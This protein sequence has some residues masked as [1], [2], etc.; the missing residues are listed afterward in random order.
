MLKLRRSRTQT[1]LLLILVLVASQGFVFY[2][3]FH[4]A[5]LPG[6]QQFNRILAYEVDLMLDQA[7]V[8]EQA[9]ALS[10]SLQRHLLKQLGLTLHHSDEPLAAEFEHATQ[11][12]FLSDDMSRDL[13]TPAEVRL[14]LGHESYVL[15]IRIEAFPH[16]L[17]RIPLSELQE[18]DFA[19]LFYNSILMALLIIGCSWVYIRLRNRPLIALEQAALKV[20]RGET[21]SPL[22]VSG[23]TEIRA[24]TKAFNQ[25]SKGIQALEDDRTLLMAGVS[26]DLRTPLTRIRL[27][28]EMMSPEEGFLAESIIQDTEEC[29]EIIGQFMDYLRP[30]EPDKYE[31]VNLNRIVEGI[32]NSEQTEQ[33]V[34]ME[35][36]LYDELKPF[37]GNP[38]A[39]RRAVT[40]LVINAIRYGHG[41]V[42]L[43]TGLSADKKQVWIC[44]EDNG[45]GI[46]AEQLNKLFEPFV[47][48]DAARGSDGTGLGLAIVKRIVVQH[49]GAVSV[50]N[51]SE[52]GL[53][54][55]VSFPV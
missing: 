26:H 49:G 53:K 22:P 33:A 6:L 9:L 20:G 11:I 42:L 5:L 34:Q 50:N 2:A 29:N 28:T 8:Q 7:E 19:P 46:D 21:P 10:P 48:G 4:Y 3:V 24:V 54:V 41:W 37:P 27:A 40:N 23:A 17:L 1:I 25:M 15:W 30:A 32:V 31:P 45:P 18:E 38:V 39:I 51:R 43:T 13:G 47:R 14:I 55:Q 12:D 16:M 52:G 36:F 35:A 44:V